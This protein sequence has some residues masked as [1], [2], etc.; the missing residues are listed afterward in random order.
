MADSTNLNS[1]RELLDQER[2]LTLMDTSGPPTSDAREEVSEGVPSAPLTSALR[3]PDEAIPAQDSDSSHATERMK[4]DVKILELRCRER[5]HRVQVKKRILKMQPETAIREREV[6]KKKYEELL[7]KFKPLSQDNLSDLLD[8]TDNS[9]PK[10][11]SAP[12]PVSDSGGEESREKHGQ[13]AGRDSEETN[14]SRI[15]R[16]TG[17]MPQNRSEGDRTSEVEDNTTDESPLST[18][19]TPETDVSNEKPGTQTKRMI[20][21]I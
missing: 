20:E 12:G 19:E 15:P 21:D 18:Q 16:R 5:E 7:D 10:L 6:A 14:L 8:I 11:V 17:R 9:F 3:P 4:G 13:K 1:L 2:I